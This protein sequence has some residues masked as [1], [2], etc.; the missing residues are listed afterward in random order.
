MEREGQDDE[1]LE[2][3]VERDDDVDPGVDDAGDVD[4][5]DV[6][7]EAVTS[8]DDTGLVAQER[9]FNQVPRQG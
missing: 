8:A 3:D 9:A 4:D 1:L 6:E 7:R 5:E 2:N